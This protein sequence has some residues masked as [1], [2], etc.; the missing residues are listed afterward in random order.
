MDTQVLNSL[1]FD[2]IKSKK[3][4]HTNSFDTILLTIEAGNVL[5]EHISNTDAYL[6]VLEGDIV[7]NINNENIAL[8]KND[9][10]AFG[11]NIPHAIT[12]QTNARMLLIK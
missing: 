6:L 5:K 1:I 9:G 4:A 12:A 8:T 2:K 7:F 11:K 3:I 10:I